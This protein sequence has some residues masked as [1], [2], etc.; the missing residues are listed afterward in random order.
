MGSNLEIVYKIDSKILFYLSYKK[1]HRMGDRIESIMK[2][3]ASLESGWKQTIVEGQ[4]IIEEQPIVEGQ[5]IVKGSKTIRSIRIGSQVNCNGD[6]LICDDSTYDKMKTL[7]EKHN[8][9]N[10]ILQNIRNNFEYS[11]EIQ[12]DE[13]EYKEFIEKLS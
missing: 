11:T 10:F 1:L 4:T 12:L 5:P 8:I 2:N 9:K 13:S 7:L 6:E 3:R